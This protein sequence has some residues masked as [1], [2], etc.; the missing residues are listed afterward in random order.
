MRCPYGTSLAPPRLPAGRFQPFP[1]GR[2]RHTRWETLSDKTAT[3]LACR[4][5]LLLIAQQ[6]AVL[7]GDQARQGTQRLDRSLRRSNRLPT[8]RVSCS[9]RACAHD[10]M[11]VNQPMPCAGTFRHLRQPTSG[12]PFGPRTQGRPAPHLQGCVTP[13]LGRTTPR[14]ALKAASYRPPCSRPA[15]ERYAYQIA[16]SA[17]P[18]T[19]LI[20]PMKR[21]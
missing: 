7:A 11:P 10:S 5:R 21:I 15:L 1:Y 6:V 4:P 12:G 17:S 3:S 8:M 14:V 19:R 2:G 20:S 18:A 9:W 16:S 13:Q